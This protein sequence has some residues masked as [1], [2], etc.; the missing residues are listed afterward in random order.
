MIMNKIKPGDWVT[1][2]PWWSESS[3]QAV[4]LQ[5]DDERPDRCWIQM[6]GKESGHPMAVY[7]NQLS[8]MESTGD[9]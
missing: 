8:P 7:A 4:F 1:Y 6:G 9:S 3:F 5:E 2:S